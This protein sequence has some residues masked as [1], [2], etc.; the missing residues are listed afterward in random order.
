MQVSVK[1]RR[2]LVVETFFYRLDVSWHRE[3]TVR[4]LL[5][6]VLAETK[7]NLCL[8]DALETSCVAMQHFSECDSSGESR[9][10]PLRSDDE[11]YDVM[12][13]EGC[14]DAAV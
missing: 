8:D 7:L 3:S 11:V 10:R 6:H 1:W 13:Y 2:R 5:V 4:E 14:A 12:N 9:Q